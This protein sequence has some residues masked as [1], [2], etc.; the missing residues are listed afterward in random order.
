MVNF[1]YKSKKLRIRVAALIENE[2]NEILLLRQQKKKKDYWLLPG[3][4]IEYGESAITALER[5]M[6]EELNVKI[7]DLEFLLLNENI[8]PKGGRH[9]IQL[10]FSAKLLPG[11]IPSLSVKQKT[12]LEFQYF[13]RESLKEIEIRPDLKNYLLNDLTKPKSIF[14]KSVWIN[15]S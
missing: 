7:T 12:I 15:E 11:S 5:E 4:G 14:L 3:G 10:V 6:E 1:F 9:L 13:T 8:D 2:K